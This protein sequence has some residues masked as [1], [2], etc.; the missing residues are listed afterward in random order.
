MPEQMSLFRRE[1]VGVVERLNKFLPVLPQIN[2]RVF[3][4]T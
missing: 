4:Q 2:I 3:Q 1:L